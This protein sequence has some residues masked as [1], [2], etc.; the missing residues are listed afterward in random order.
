MGQA[1]YARVG[2]WIER[3]EKRV[4]LWL[5]TLGV[6]STAFEELGGFDEEFDLLEVDIDLSMRVHRAG[7][8]LRLLP[9]VVAFHTGGGTPMLLSHRLLRFYA[10]RWRALGKHRKMRYPWAC[11][12][13]ILLR[14]CVERLVLRLLG[15]RLFPDA[16]V[17]RDKLQGRDRVIRY[18]RRNYH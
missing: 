5:C 17:R 16:A 13:A 12:S 7:K 2:P 10:N 9:D 6:R 15:K 4:V 1:L 8:R 3:P 14:L 18:C 11:K